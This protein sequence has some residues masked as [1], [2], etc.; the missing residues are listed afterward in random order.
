MDIL[1]ESFGT[2]VVPYMCADSVYEY[3]GGSGQSRPQAE[4]YGGA[5]S[6]PS[7]A[8]LCGSLSV[9]AAAIFP[10]RFGS[11]DRIVL[12]VGRGG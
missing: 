3:A 9:A 10:L 2:G 1:K 6:Y 8:A 7:V 12:E 5:V 11:G 4:N